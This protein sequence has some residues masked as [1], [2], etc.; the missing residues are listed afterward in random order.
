MKQEQVMK[1]RMGEKPLVM[2]TKVATTRVI[3]VVIEVV[4]TM[5]I[6]RMIATVIVKAT[7]VKTKIANKVT[8]IGVNP[9]VIENMKM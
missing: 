5:E 9:L 1:M 4:V 8:M 6:V 3:V 7:R 2:I